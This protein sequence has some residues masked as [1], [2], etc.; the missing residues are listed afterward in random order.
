MADSSIIDR[1]DAA[2]LR[3]TLSSLGPANWYAILER[4]PEVYLQVGT[5]RHAGVPDGRFALELRDGTASQHYRTVVSDLSDIIEAFV[6]FASGATK[7]RDA[8][9]WQRLTL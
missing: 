4:G 2:R 8:F 5:G 1:P 3:T 6:A 9:S 7:W